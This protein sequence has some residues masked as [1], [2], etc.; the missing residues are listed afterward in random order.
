MKNFTIFFLFII[1]IIN[2]PVFGQYSVKLRIGEIVNP[3]S[4]EHPFE[5][6]VT[7][8]AD[9]F[10]ANKNLVPHSSN[11]HYYW[12]KNECS[13]GEVLWHEGDDLYFLVPDGH[14]SIPSEC[15]ETITFQT[16]WVHVNVRINGILYYSGGVRIPDDESDV[17]TQDRKSTRLNSSHV[18]IS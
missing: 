18:R 13:G 5:W 7:I 4:P 8:Y 2:S 14:N 1:L 6:R 10:D 12:Y 3:L 17:L 16:Y 15:D 9:I 11:Y